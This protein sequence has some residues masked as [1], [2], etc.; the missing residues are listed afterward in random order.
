MSG[1]NVW[2]HKGTFLL[3]AVGSAVGLGN[4]WRFP[5]LVGENGGGAFILIYALTIFAVG[6]PILIAEIMLG[7]TSRQSPIMGMRH[8]TK[9]HRTSRAWESIGWLGAAS[10]FLILSFYSVI[11]GWAIHYTW[12]MLTGSLVGADAQTIS[13]GFDALLAAPGL[14]TLYHTL[15]IAA[16]TLIVGMG[17]HSGI[18]AGLRIMMPALFVILLV[19]LAYSVING[20]VG[21]AATFLFTFNLADLS[22]EGWLQAMGQ[23]FFTLSLGMGAIM[24]YGAYMPSNVSLTRTAF[25]VAIVD[26]AVAMVAGLAIFALVFGAGLETG[27][28]PGLMFVTLPLAFSNMPMG[29]LVGGVF[30]ILVL[31]AAISSSISLIEPVAAFLVE[32]FDMTRPQAVAIMATAAWAMGLLTVVSFNVWAEGTIFHLLFGRTA[33]DFIE[34]LT[35]IFMPIGGLMIAL[36]AGWTL[37]QSEVMK[38]LGTNVTWFRCWRFLVRF[39][40]PAAVAFVFL[41]TIPLVDGYLIPTLGALLIVGAFAASQRWL[42]KPRQIT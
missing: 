29:A 9:T 30:F 27:Q 15:F 3:A 2:T 17:V 26:T 6:I 35:N 28:G 13:Q 36:F 4:L 16:S 21:A 24:A 12:L 25:A 37:T 8:L 7:R 39:V 41:R 23:S 1:H 14:M 19:V 10:A 11:A 32:R 5:Y 18:E 31:G 42:K 33:F 20:D 22:L 34:L 40:A 38:E